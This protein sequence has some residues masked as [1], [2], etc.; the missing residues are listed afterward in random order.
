M[1]NRWLA[2]IVRACTISVL[3]VA[4]IVIVHALRHGWESV[5]QPGDWIEKGI[6]FVIFAAV[7]TV[8]FGI[9]DRRSAQ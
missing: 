1:K 4:A 9:L 7:Y 5:N 2:A 8:F 3:I 6:L